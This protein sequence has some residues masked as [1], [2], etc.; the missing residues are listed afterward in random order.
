MLADWD[1][2][3]PG[4]AWNIFKSLSN[5]APS[6]LMDQNLFDFAGLKPDGKLNAEGDTAFDPPELLPDNSSEQAISISL[7]RS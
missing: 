5:I 3:Y 6:H 4:R 2:K 7:L 1:K